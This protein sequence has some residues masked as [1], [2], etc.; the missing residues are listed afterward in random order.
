MAQRLQTTIMALVVAAGLGTTHAQEEKGVA[1]A[2]HR[3]VT[4]GFYRSEGYQRTEVAHITGNHFA[5]GAITFNE[6]PEASDPGIGRWY[7]YNAAD[8]RMEASGGFGDGV[9]TVRVAGGCESADKA[10]VAPGWAWFAWE[11]DGG[12]YVNRLDS[13]GRWLDTSTFIADA[14]NPKLT[15]GWR[16]DESKIALFY[17]VT[18]A[19][20]SYLYTRFL[21]CDGGIGPAYALRSVGSPW[22]VWHV[23]AAFNPFQSHWRVF[24]DERNADT[25][26]THMRT[27][28]LTWSGHHSTSTYLLTCQNGGPSKLF[29]DDPVEGAEGKPPLLAPEETEWQED[30]PLPGDT[31]AHPKYHYEGCKRF[32]A[33]FDPTT[34]N[35][36]H[37]YLL[38]TYGSNLHLVSETG[39]LVETRVDGEFT[40]PVTGVCSASWCSYREIREV[41]DGDGLHSRFTDV[42]FTDKFNFDCSS[43]SGE[44]IT[45]SIRLAR[46]MAMASGNAVTV[47]LY[48]ETAADG[49]NELYLTVIED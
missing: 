40:I 21:G 37:R 16:D 3:Y 20:R 28:Y 31:G 34:D 33:S 8:N 11:K 7:L 12:V 24:W 9:Q 19:A 44:E 49:D 5:I 41:S 35:S 47:V 29:H 14:G 38:S 18:S 36:T 25:M 43:S 22:H 39:A 2:D 4:T 46:P 27:K 48:S 30:S 6:E 13:L 26:E 45:P 1:G 23:E 32:Y 42:T 10:I 17:E 15:E